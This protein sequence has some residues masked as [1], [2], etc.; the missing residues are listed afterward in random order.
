MRSITLTL[1]AVAMFATTAHANDCWRHTEGSEV[2]LTSYWTA[3][4]YSWQVFDPVANA[5]VIDV[6]TTDSSVTFPHP[7]EGT[8]WVTSSYRAL[9]Y[10]W[11]PPCQVD[12]TLSGP[13]PVEPI[14]WG[15]I[16]AAYR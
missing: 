16:K 5:I 3:D 14:N 13:E 15:A 8:Y 6:E 12:L 1:I 10:P 7:G 11:Q 9:P 4:T 2:T